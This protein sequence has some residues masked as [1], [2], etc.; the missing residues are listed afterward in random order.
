MSWAE[1]STGHFADQHQFCSRPRWADRPAS[2]PISPDSDEQ[3]EA[4]LALSCGTRS[5]TLRV[6]IEEDSGAAPA[7]LV[8]AQVEC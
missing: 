4:R 3:I 8:R 7:P 6:L 2:T 1:R 5:W